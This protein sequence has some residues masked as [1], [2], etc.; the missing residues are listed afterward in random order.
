MDQC[1]GNPKERSDNHEIATLGGGCF[2]CL[3]AV[4]QELEGVFEVISGYAG[5]DL[6]NPTYDHQKVPHNLAQKSHL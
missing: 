1:S 4:F 6:A 5:G 3:E 2:W